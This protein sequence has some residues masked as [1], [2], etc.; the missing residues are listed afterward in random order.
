M[1]RNVA[2]VSIGAD[3][4]NC[5]SD[6][7]AALTLRFVQKKILGEAAPEDL[8]SSDSSLKYALSLV[9]WPALYHGSLGP[10][11]TLLFITILTSI[12]DI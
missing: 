9:A 10:A 1:V 5:N 8:D 2:K 7:T 11:K 12:K 6:K 4:K 3:S